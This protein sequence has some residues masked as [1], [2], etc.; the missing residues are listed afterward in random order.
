MLWIKSINKYKP[1][2]IVVLSLWLV[3]LISILVINDCNAFKPYPVVELKE[4]EMHEER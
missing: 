2:I 4:D 1:L 3:E